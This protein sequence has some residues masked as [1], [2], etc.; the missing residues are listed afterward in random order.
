MGKI[1]TVGRIDKDG[2]FHSVGDSDILLEELYDHPSAKHDDL[3]DAEAY[4]K[5]IIVT[6]LA[7]EEKVYS[8]PQSAE[9]SF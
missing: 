9:R 5:D 6:P 2:Y 4:G 8:T 1:I 3:S 7:D